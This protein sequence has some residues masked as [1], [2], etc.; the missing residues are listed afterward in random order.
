MT[1]ELANMFESTFSKVKGHRHQRDKNHGITSSGGAIGGSSEAAD[2]C[3]FT[4][5]V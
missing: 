4:L 5:E 1:S 2:T 3:H